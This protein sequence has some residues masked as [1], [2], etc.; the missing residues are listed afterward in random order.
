MLALGMRA[1]V[2]DT[3]ADDAH[4]LMEVNFYGPLRCIHAVLPQMRKQRAGQ[5]VNVGS[6]LSMIASPRNSA[7][8]ASK[9]A[10]LALSDSLAP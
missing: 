2:E 1:P 4:Y 3:P 10:L 8:C 9:F 6:V 7:Y 5:I